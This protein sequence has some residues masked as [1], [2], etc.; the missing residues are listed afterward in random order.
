M[1]REEVLEAI[2]TRHAEGQPVVGLSS[3]CAD[4]YRAARKG[5]GGWYEAVRAAGVPAKLPRQWSHDAVIDAI[6]RRHQHGPPL[7]HVWRDDKPLFRAA[8]SYFGNWHTALRAAGL[9]VVPPRRWSREQI[10]DSLQDHYRRG[11]PQIRAFDP[12]LA[13][14]GLRYFGS[15]S[16][17]VEAAGLPPPPGRWNERKIID[18]IQDYYVKGLP[19]Q[20]R[21]CKDALLA[22]AAKRHFGSWRAAVAAAGLLT[23]VPQLRAKRRWSRQAVIDAIRDW[24]RQG[25]PAKFV[26][27]R[28]GGLYSAAKAQFGSWRAAVLAAGFKPG[29]KIWTRQIIVQEIQ[30][31]KQQGL[32]LSSQECANWCLATAAERYFGSWNEALRAAGVEL[33]RRAPSRRPTKKRRS[34]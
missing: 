34:A 12:R 23:R 7:N 27:K 19:I 13:N 10:L 5:F 32:S 25:V 16:N 22:E 9:A 29:R 26:W 17:A 24:H 1:T 31:R 2:R 18:T 33:A 30:S 28:D 6:R 4:L 14:A 3:T 20:F 21:G 15:L 11:Q 8:V